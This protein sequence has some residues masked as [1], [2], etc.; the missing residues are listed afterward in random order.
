[1]QR[2]GVILRWNTGLL[3]CKL[4][5]CV[6]VVLL[7]EVRWLLSAQGFDGG[8]RIV[9]TSKQRGSPCCTAL[10]LCAL[11]SSCFLIGILDVVRSVQYEDIEV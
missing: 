6:S 8:I 1:M 11:P 9:N 7:C 10:L 4:F 2:T 3:S 5:E